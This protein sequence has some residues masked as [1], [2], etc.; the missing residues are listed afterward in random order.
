MLDE[1]NVISIPKDMAPP[2]FYLSPLLACK[3]EKR[4]GYMAENRKGFG[5]LEV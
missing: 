1:L 5:R 4:A 2:F 3:R